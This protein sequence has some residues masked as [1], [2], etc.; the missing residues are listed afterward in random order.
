MP[1]MPASGWWLALLIFFML[2][3]A[4]IIDARTGRV[5][6]P[7]ILA[8]L[9]F[10]TAIQGFFVTWPFAA[11]HLAIA[12]A[13]GFLPYLLNL[14]WYRLK[15]RDALGMG[16]AKWT[17]LA[18]DC[19]GP[20]PSVIAWFLGAW[21]ALAWMALMKVAGRPKRHVHFAPFLLVG[22]MAG[23]YWMRLR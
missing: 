19:F 21:L 18:V 6:D 17:M 5:P 4:S 9:V 20:L 14:F 10:T 7:I 1:G 15:K 12:L 13:A 16:D 23:I 8:G 22:L 2:A 11:R 3:V